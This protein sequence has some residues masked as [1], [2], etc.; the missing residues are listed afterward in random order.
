MFVNLASLCPDSAE[1]AKTLIPSL[2]GKI[3]DDDLEELLNEMGR[4]RSIVQ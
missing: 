1:E 3:S 2:E 4:L